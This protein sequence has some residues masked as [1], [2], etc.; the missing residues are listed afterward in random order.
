MFF[1]PLPF[2]LATFHLLKTSF[3]RL[4]WIPIHLGET[5]FS[6]P[7]SLKKALYQI[8][9]PMAYSLGEWI[10]VIKGKGRK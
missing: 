3:G 8:A 2:W 7:Y 1:K 4:L 9:Q 6:R 10:G 5:I